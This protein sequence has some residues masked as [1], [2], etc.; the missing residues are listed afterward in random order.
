M[1]TDM[2]AI[3]RPYAK[4]AFEYAL[5]HNALANWS[6]FLEHLSQITADALFIAFL[7]DPATTPAQHSQLLEAILERFKLLT[8]DE[9]LRNFVRLLA[10]NKRL[11]A[12]HS[13]YQNF[14]HLR[15]EYEKTLT[16]EVISFSELSKEQIKKLTYR[17]GQRLQRDIT[18]NIT[19]DPSIMGG[20]I[21]RTENFVFDGSVRTQ[22]KNLSNTLAA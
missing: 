18:I 3:A 8:G 22:I 11:L 21:I 4:A 1:M 19:I 6:R 15:A 7:N 20:A 2:T 9:H 17:L 13:I 16:V 12:S 10:R 14:E 5:E